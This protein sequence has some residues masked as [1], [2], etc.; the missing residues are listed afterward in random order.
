MRRMTKTHKAPTWY[1]NCQCFEEALIS[2]FTYT[3]LRLGWCARWTQGLYW[4]ELNVPTPVFGGSRYRHLIVCSRRLQ[5]SERGKIS[6]SQLGVSA[7]IILC[8]L[9]SS[10]LLEGSSPFYRS[11][12]RGYNLVVW[13]YH[14]EGVGMLIRQLRLFSSIIVSYHWCHIFVDLLREV[15]RRSRAAVQV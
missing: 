12:E 9:C 15:L 6:R 8:V 3:R 5:T 7:S 1:I 10:S 14:G 13:C 2:K 4:F 11:K